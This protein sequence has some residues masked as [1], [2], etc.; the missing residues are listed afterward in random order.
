MTAHYEDNEQAA[1]F[2]WAA[3]IPVLKFMHA[4]PNGAFLAGDRVKRARQMARLKRQGLRKGVSDIFLPLARHGHHGL[5]I[6]MK[7][8]KSDGNSQVSSDQKEFQQAMMIEGYWAEVCYGADEAIKVIK[9]YA[10]I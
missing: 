3:F 4:I 7:R 1:V 10:E 2:Q 8:R 5:Y 9:E 6:E